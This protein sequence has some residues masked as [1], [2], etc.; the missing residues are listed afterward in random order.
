MMSPEV[1]KFFFKNRYK[2][3]RSR[4]IVRGSLDAFE[5]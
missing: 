4:N 3:E 2:E 1:K 5:V